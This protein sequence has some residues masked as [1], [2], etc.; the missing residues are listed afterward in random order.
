MPTPAN[1]ATVAGHRPTRNVTSK[2]SR[3]S[4][5]PSSV[6]IGGAMTAGGP[7]QHLAVVVD[8]RRRDGQR[9]PTGA[10]PGGVPARAVEQ[11]PGTITGIL[12]AD[13]RENII[14]WSWTKRSEYPQRYAQAASDP[15]N[16]HLTLIRASSDNDA[17][18]LVAATALRDD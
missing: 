9:D 3:G 11:Q 5:E 2:A 10:E 14:L 16:A 15:A 1:S 4:R 13:R 17:D 18:R 8:R 12:S 6:L 7:R